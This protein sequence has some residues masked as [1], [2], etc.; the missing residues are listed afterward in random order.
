MDLNKFSMYKDFRLLRK[1]IREDIIRVMP[2]A[3][4]IPDAF[5]LKEH[6]AALLRLMAEAAFTKSPLEKKDCAEG[7]LYELCL[8]RD[9]VE[10]QAE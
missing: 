7:M 5:F 8:L 2:R 6:L 1:Y 9:E 10:Q 4:K 3:F